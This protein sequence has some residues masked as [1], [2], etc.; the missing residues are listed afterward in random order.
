MPASDPASLETFTMRP[1]PLA[2]SKGNRLRLVCQAPSRLTSSA[3]RTT[4]RFAVL[5]CYQVS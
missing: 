1:W 2:R 5:A 4:W 3:S